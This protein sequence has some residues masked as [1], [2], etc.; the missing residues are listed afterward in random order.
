MLGPQLRW[1]QLLQSSSDN[2][3]LPAL[4]GVFGNAPSCPSMTAPVHEDTHWYYQYVQT[5]LEMCLDYFNI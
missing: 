2:V 3:M 1:K 4:G 5:R